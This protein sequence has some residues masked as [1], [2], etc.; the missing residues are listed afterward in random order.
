MSGLPT[1]EQFQPLVGQ[2]FTLTYPDYRETLT[3]VS[4]TRS[5]FAPPPGLPH[6]FDLIFDGESRTT[7]LGQAIYALENP[8]LGT[9]DLFLSCFGRQAEGNFRYQAVIN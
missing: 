3:L 1:L 9:V 5:P 6:G 2:G 4:A 8:V 7:M